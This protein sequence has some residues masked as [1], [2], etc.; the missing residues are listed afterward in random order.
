MTT[1]VQPNMNTIPKADV[2]SLTKAQNPIQ[3][4]LLIALSIVT[5]WT[6]YMVPSWQAL[7]DPFLL[8]AV[9]GA[10]TVVC[11]WLTRWLGSR[12]M[13]FERAWLAAFLVA[14]PLVYV[15]GWFAARDRAATLWI[16]VELLGLALF[17]AFAALG[18][19]KSPWFLVLGIAGHGLAWD[20]WH[21]KNSS[22]APDWYAV[23]CLLVD[24]VLGAYVAARVP[25]YREAWRI[26][27][28]N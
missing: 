28:N 27:K 11:L 24:L 26:A 2:P 7:G 15:M 9:A 6:L 25:A 14:M 18:F 12:A 5:V 13:K 1:E 10:V 4:V 16:W 22:Y 3:T 20:S 8:A 23:A 19:K 21:Y 17:A